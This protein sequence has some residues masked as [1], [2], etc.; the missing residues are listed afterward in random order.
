VLLI[1]AGFAFALVLAGGALGLQIPTTTVTT[2]PLP[3]TT[4]TTPPLPIVPTTTIT[5]PPVPTTTVTT[6]PVTPPPS[7]PPSPPAPPP[8]L[9]KL[10]SPPKVPTPP[11][12]PAPSTLPTAG[13]SPVSPSGTPTSSSGASAG[14]GTGTSARSSSGSSAGRTSTTSAAA[15]AAFG[16]AAFRPSQDP[17]YL[18]GLPSSSAVAL[19]Y[20]AF[21]LPAD[22]V[23]NSLR[24]LGR[25]APNGL[26]AGG[27]VDILSILG[28]PDFLRDGRAQAG[29]RSGG[30]LSEV[31]GILGQQATLSDTGDGGGLTFDHLPLLALALV[32]LSSILLLGSVVPPGVVARTGLSPAEYARARQALALAAIGILI[33][34]AVV[35]FLFGLG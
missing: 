12:S 3:T 1:A 10:P 20:G 16:R 11:A 30:G 22:G 33:T 5:T 8:S 4:I 6:P 24:R 28:L 23:A 17:P 34:V 35:A 19:D 18:A 13:A 26:L 32:L 31:Q 7:P 15:G 25:L 29:R 9:P 27:E 14:A 2:P 21:I